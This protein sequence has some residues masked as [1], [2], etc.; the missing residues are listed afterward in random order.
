MASYVAS[1][2][3]MAL[4]QLWQQW[5]QLANVNGNASIVSFSAMLLMA[6]SWQWLQRNNGI[7]QWLANVNGEIFSVASAA[8]RIAASAAGGVSMAGWRS[9]M[10][11]AI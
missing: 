3:I 10:W 4:N 9:S 7:S 1:M 11:P 6:A 5:R 8:W 2:Y